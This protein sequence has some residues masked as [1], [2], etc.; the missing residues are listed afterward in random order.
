M[1]SSIIVKYSVILADCTQ[2]N[3]IK[4]SWPCSVWWE[5]EG[6]GD[7]QA[8]K[9]T[10]EPNQNKKKKK[11]KKKKRKEE[12]KKKKKKKKGL[13]KFKLWDESFFIYTR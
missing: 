11:E 8:D 6:G 3:I 2:I 13:F 1:I 9:Q 12:K 10:N 7:R 5:R 4:C